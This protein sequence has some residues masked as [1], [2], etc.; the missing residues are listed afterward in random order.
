MSQQG[1]VDKTQETYV[2]RS[3]VPSS[4]SGRSSRSSGTS[5]GTSASAAATKARAKAEAARVQV[6]YAEKEA[7]MMREKAHIEA[8]KAEVEAD[9]YVLQK[10]KSAIAASAEAAVYEAAAEVEE[11]PLKDLAQITLEDRAQRTKEYVQ[12]H[13]LLSH[14][15]QQAPVPQLLPVTPPVSQLRPVAPPHAENFQRDALHSRPPAKTANILSSTFGLKDEPVND[16][17]RADYSCHPQSPVPHASHPR[18][19]ACEAPQTTDLAKYLIRREMVSSGLLKFD[20]RPENYWAWKMSFQDTTRDLNLTAREELDLLTKWLGPESSSQAMRIRSVHVHNPTAGV[21]MIWQRLEDSYGCPEVIENALLQRLENFPKISNKDNQRLM[22]LGDI[23]ME[24]ESAKSGGHLPGLA[25]LNT[26]RGVNPIVEKLPY[27]LQERWVT[28]GSKYKEDYRVPFPPFNFFVK[29][30]RSQAKIRNDP[31]FAFSTS[32]SS[33]HSRPEKPERYN[34]RT[35]VSVRKTEVSA[36]SPTYQ[37]S[38]SG[39]KADETNIQ[40]PIH[41]KPHPL[42]K[43]RG[44]R[45]KHLDERKAYL[46]E[47]YICFRCCSSTKH[48]AKDCKAAVRCKECNSDKHI[49]ALHAGPAPWSVEALAKEQEHGGERESSSSL[50]IT[51]KCTEI[52]GKTLGPRSCSKICLVHVYPTNRPDKAERMYAVLDEQSNRSLVKSEFFRLFG[53]DGD[54]SSYILKTCAG[55]M[56]T[57][58]RKASN[59][60]VASLDGKTQVALPPLLECNMMPDDRSEIPTPDIS[61]YFPH[62]EPVADKILPPDANAP[63]LLLLGRDILSVHKVREQYNGPR[64]TPYAQRLDLG[65]VIVGEV[66][67]GGAHKPS[68]VNVFRTN[69]LQNGRT[70]FLEPCNGSIHVKEKFSAPIQ[71]HSLNPPFGLEKVVP[72]TNTD[73]IGGKVFQR[74]PDDDKLAPSVED[75]IFLEI[76]DR[77]AY[78]DESNHWVAPLPF[79]SPRSSL[80]NNRSQALKR[81]TTLQRMLQKK[82]DMRE[83]FVDFMQ[84]IFD[85]DQAEP[86]PP[87]KPGEECW[88]LPIF[89]VYHPQ[90]PGKIRVVFDSSAQFEGISLNDTLLSGPD[91]NNTLLGVL[92]R[93]RREQVA[94]TVDVEQMF[95]CF[96]VRED[97]RNYLRF[98]WFKD[99]DLKNEITEFRMKVHVFGNSPSPAVA[100]YGL[101][102]AADMGEE[103]HGSDAKQFVHRNFYVD[104]G[105]TSV[106][107][108]GEAIDLLKRTRN[109][110]AESNIRLHKIASNSN[111]VMDAFLPEER[112]KDLK[113]LDLG[114]DP[115]PLQRSLGVSWNLQTDSFTFQVA[116][117]AKPFT[118]R[119]ILSAVNSLYD[120]L[121][122]VAPITMQGKALFR[123]LSSGQHEWDEPLPAE[124]EAQWR[125]W[126]DSLADLKQLEIHRPYVPVSLSCTQK[127]E[128]YV[129]SD[130]STTAIAAAAYLRVVDNDGQCHV[131]FIMGKTKLAPYPA[132]TVPRLEL[133]AAVLAVE[134]A[135]LVTEESDIELHG[136]KFYTDSRIVLGYIHNNTRRFY[137][138]VANRV[139]RIRKSTKPEQWHHVG[140]DQNPADHGTRFIPASRLQHTSWLSGPEFLRQA[141]SEAYEEPACF[142]L[143]EPSGD[144][145]I[146]PQVTTL[147]TKATEQLLESHRFERFS[148]WSSLVRGMA[149]LT[150]IARSFSRTS[151]TGNCTGWHCCDSL[152]TTERSQAK[153]AIIRCVQYEVYKGE[154]KSLTKKEEISHR[155]PLKKLDPFIDEEGLMRVGGRLQSADL[156]ELEKHPLIIPANHHVATLLVRHYH[157]KVAH[158]GRQFTEGA[159]R[160][161]G[162]WVVGGKRLVSSLVHKCVTCRKLRGRLE[163][164]KMA[165]LPADRVTVDPPF[166]HVGLDVFGPWAITSRRTRGNSAEN[167]RWA[168]IFTCLSTRAVHLEVIESMSSSSFVN[169]LRRFLSIRGPVKHLRSDRGTNFVGACKELKIN[170]ADPEIKGYLQDQGCTWTFNSPHSSHMGGAWERL[171]GVVRH[172]LDGLLLK[173][174]TTRLTHEVLTTLMAEVMAMMNARPLV[175]VSSD[176]ETPEVLSPA[177]LL[178]QKASVV[179]A[180][181]GDFELRDLY[182]SQWRQVQSLADSFW[183]KW[184]QEYLATLQTRRKWKGVKSNIQ[185]GDVVL[186]KDS[187]VRRNEWPVGLIVKAMPSG[188][189]K[190]RKV[191]VRIVKQGTAKTY[192]RPVTELILLLSEN[193]Q[194]D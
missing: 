130:A 8:R 20:D 15:Q 106:A 43:C 173:T 94:V 23:L 105:L 34:N 60:T 37:D 87:L 121:G 33:S 169:A 183:K 35:P 164:Q 151:C 47:K 107:S 79:R 29:F 161:A 118:R 189:N 104:D 57:A 133:C 95:Y 128:I 179:S 9:L 13:S 70:S 123:E 72:A 191:E 100:T 75:G 36:T 163:E 1:E 131:G 46:R 129:F 112:A 155:S 140:T 166:T 177:M 192:L 157:N 10:E 88:Y 17:R 18:D 193:G 180:P 194:K 78:I 143:V 98:L 127:R 93:F 99:N 162:L 59:F 53:I 66:C 16:T 3:Q 97:H 92:L 49:S 50:E 65:W 181:P 55:K 171:I 103:E 82:M 4:K 5:Y 85:N 108:D 74:N 28:Q 83:H 184:R 56:E 147:V 134:L 136:V 113:D 132:H 31:S 175:P 124:T 120:P 67:L 110:M 24:V 159:L 90:K 145:E 51:S 185:E 84:K 27:G 102:R 26:A 81:L 135:E 150:H 58:G 76:M 77:E 119:G 21:H 62:L 160:T 38:T 139:T 73:N 25:Y 186:L 174:S 68:N 40:C 158:Q 149:T 7:A 19:F 154:L 176:P 165:N 178:T 86:A 111:Q 137:V 69:V 141:D 80:P 52:C 152:H 41:N 61:Q 187:Q 39:K 144:E 48:M 116:Q 63:I 14:T 12:T 71:Q 153:T 109:M 32:S 167:K 30:I 96:M 148:S 22:E 138:Y 126:T 170:V 114:V 146:R 42:A 54:P 91:L 190:V 156:T 168:V 117:D 89:G 64:N 101:R 6:S 44:F 182:R 125:T 188:D 122:F 45:A 115:L 2:I 11:G 142:E 172:I